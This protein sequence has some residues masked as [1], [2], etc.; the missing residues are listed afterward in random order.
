M[1]TCLALSRSSVHP[2]VM[3]QLFTTAEAAIYLGQTE[4]WVRK[5]LKRL[6][7]KIDSGPVRCGPRAPMHWRKRDLD[8]LL[9][10]VDWEAL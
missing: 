2:S 9:D 6:L 3:P 5:S 10:Q 4:D 7:W 1:D 8:W